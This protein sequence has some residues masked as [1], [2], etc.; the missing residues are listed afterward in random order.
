MTYSKSFLSPLIFSLA[1][2]L[3][4]AASALLIMPAITPEATLTQPE[5]ERADPVAAKD[6]TRQNN[7][8]S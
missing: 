5:H 2:L 7:Q 6:T 3:P 4:V 8:A 1:L